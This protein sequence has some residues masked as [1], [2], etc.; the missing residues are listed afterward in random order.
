VNTNAGSVPSPKGV[1]SLVIGHVDAA[2][3]VLVQ[4]GTLKDRSD[5]P[6]EIV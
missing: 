5:W 2:A 1:R 4:L 6:F 3:A